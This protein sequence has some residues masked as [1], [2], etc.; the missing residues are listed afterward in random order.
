MS[1][2]V[3]IKK[4][5]TVGIGSAITDFS[6]YGA[7]LHFA[8][9]SPEVA[10]LVSRPCGALFSFTF[11]KVWTFERVQLAGTHLEVIRFSIVWIIAYCA[12]I[13]FIW[14][15]HQFFISHPT[16]PAALSDAIQHILGMEINLVKVLPKLCTEGLLC[17]GIFLSHRL[18]TYNHLPRHT[19]P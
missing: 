12:S 7:L 4:Y 11:N 5:A 10:N 19:L 6:I 1:L 13:L 3:Q 2:F 15:F 14:L 17:I 16:L 18:W 9:C 8:N